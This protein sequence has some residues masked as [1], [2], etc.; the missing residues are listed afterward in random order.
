MKQ[1]SNS[2]K[3]KNYGFSRI[4]SGVLVISLFVTLL[5]FILIKLFTYQIAILVSSMFVISVML[6]F[7]YSLK[8]MEIR[9]NNFEVSN[10]AFNRK[11][12]FKTNDLYMNF[13]YPPAST[14]S[15]EK[16]QIRIL[17]NDK[18]LIEFNKDENIEIVHHLKNNLNIKIKKWN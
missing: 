1:Q 16:A 13:H 11:E 14:W 18:L 10:I 5:Y 2:L 17:K 4:V 6:T 9:G 15:G 12:Y 8:V 7:F 3:L